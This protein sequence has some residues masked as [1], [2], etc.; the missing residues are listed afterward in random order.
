VEALDIFRACKNRDDVMS[1]SGELKALEKKYLREMTSF[2]LYDFA[3]ETRVS[4][5]ME[6]YRVNN[7]QRATMKFF[8]S[9]GDDIMPGESVSVVVSDRIA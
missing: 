7:L 8:S 2:D 1:M 9:F 6:E 4:R 3:L 5:H